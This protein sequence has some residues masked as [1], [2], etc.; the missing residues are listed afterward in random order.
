MIWFIFFKESAWVL[1]ASQIGRLEWGAIRM[2]LKKSRQEMRITRITSSLILDT[3][4]LPA[5]A[6]SSF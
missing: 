4:P 1:C 3:A 6:L 5:L 2:L